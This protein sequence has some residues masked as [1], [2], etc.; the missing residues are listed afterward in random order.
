M[1]GKM[2]LVDKV[3]A[4]KNKE[5]MEDLKKNIRNVVPFLGAGISVPYGYF[6]WLA[7][8]EHLLKVAERIVTISDKDK[9]EVRQY[10]DG[11][12]YLKA[13]DTL[14][15][16][17]P[18]L[19]DIVCYEIESK[20]MKNP[21]TPENQ[22]ILG[23]YLQLFPSKTYLTTNYDNVVE[24]VLR[25]TFGNRLRTVVPGDKDTPGVNLS[26]MN[27]GTE[28]K[29]PILYYLH[30]NF[31]NPE[32]I[33]LS[34][35]HYNQFY[36][37]SNEED[38]IDM[39]R[40]LTKDLFEL[41][42]G[43]FMFLFLGCGMSIAEDRVLQMFKRINAIM[44]LKE[45]NYVL[46]N[47][48]GVDDP[49]DKERELLALKVRPIWFSTDE[50][51][52]DDAIREL[53]EFILGEER[54]KVNKKNEAWTRNS[55]V[56][57]RSLS[58]DAVID[59]SFI[60]KVEKFFRGEDEEGGV[61]LKKMRFQ[62]PMFTMAERIYEVYLVK[63]DGEFYL[64]DDGTTHAELDKIFELGVPDVTKNLEAILK[65]YRC[66][67][68]PNTNAYIIDCKEQ[69]YQIKYSFLVQAISFMLNM[70]IFYI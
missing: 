23:E 53:F 60:D 61:G 27:L 20:I 22:S 35:R 11:K 37:Y 44:K 70:K 28:Q 13:T 45:F 52:Y 56:E 50:M 36:G 38:Q 18:N 32:S 55:G 9:N 39:Q 14:D 49:V 8:L 2:R 59:A 24:Q 26:R 69:D 25:L 7:F 5:Y 63:E 1:E 48:K 33:I 12:K 54:E 58:L 31:E 41:Y 34:R 4:N 57:D 3:N 43:T 40:N 16:L 15:R 62:F 17:V 30:G 42:K 19:N 65:H 6:T 21:I 51:T 46:L 10:L 64:S 47:K 66:K 29:E 67:L 68:H